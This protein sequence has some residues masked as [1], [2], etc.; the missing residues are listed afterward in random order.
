[1]R[2][3]FIVI[4]FSIALAGCQSTGPSAFTIP[5][6]SPREV[7]VEYSVNEDCSSVGDTV[8]RVTQQ[9]EHGSVEVRSGAV[10][11]RF[12]DSNPRHACNARTVD[13]K[14]IWYNPA[15]GFAGDDHFAIE[16]IYPSGGSHE[17]SFAVTVR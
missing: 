11:T 14:Q 4:L 12:A 13:G 9:P 3:G 1:M 8:V 10:H 6:G 7:G 15:S 5:V 16:A 2:S 17:S